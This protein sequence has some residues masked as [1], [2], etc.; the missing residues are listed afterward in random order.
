MIYMR[1]SGGAKLLAAYGCNALICAVG[2]WYFVQRAKQ[3]LDFAFTVHFWH[4]LFV[5]LYNRIFP[6]YLSWWLLQIVCVA[7]TT[8]LGEY[9]C[10]RTELKA[11]P[12]SL[13]P[14]VDL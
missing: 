1:D 4:L 5:W 8:V 3:C 10:L 6:S 9:L 7:V 11:I 14:K 13:G 2:L 12:V